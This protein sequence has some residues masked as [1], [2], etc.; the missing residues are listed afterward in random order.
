MATCIFAGSFLVSFI[1]YRVN[2]GVNSVALLRTYFDV[3]RGALKPI[4]LLLPNWGA[5]L[6]ISSGLFERYYNS[7]IMV[8]ERWWGAYVGFCALLGLAFLF[9][10]GIWRQLNKRSPSLPFLSVCWIIAYVGVGGTHAIVS[11]ILNFYD[12]RATNRYSAAIATIGLL[13]FVFMLHRLTRNWSSK[14]RVL[15]L[16]LVALLAVIDQSFKTQTFSSRH[17]FSIKARVIADR[18]LASKLEDRLKDGAM[19]YILPV[20]S[21]PEPFPGRAPYELFSLYDPIR[22]FLY[23]SKLRYSYGSNK[24][25]QGADW[26]LDVQSLPVGEMAA[27]L[28]SYGF[29]GILLNRECYEDCGEGLLEELAEV[30]WP[31]EFEQGIDNEWVFIRLTPSPKPIFPTPTPYALSEENRL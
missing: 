17:D 15:T 8:G 11:L 12:I 7:A 14:A 10:K 2:H 22:P 30:G 31:M 3:E 13:Y 16:S 5:H 20:L 29:S 25:R 18:N 19:I 9:S 26:Q 27:V 4:E 23:S 24:G 21:F 1:I 28:E 6:G